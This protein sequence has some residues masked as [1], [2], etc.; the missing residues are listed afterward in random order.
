MGGF[1]YLGLRQCGAVNMQLIQGGRDYVG[2]VVENE[3]KDEQLLDFV[4]RTV[5]KLHYENNITVT[6]ITIII[7]DHDFLPP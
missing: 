2:Y 5:L 4:F 3:S 7:I 1:I 6:S